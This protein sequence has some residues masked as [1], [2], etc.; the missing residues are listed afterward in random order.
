MA[1]GA[2]TWCSWHN[3]P[4]DDSVL[5]A[6]QDAGSAAGGVFLYACPPCRRKYGLVPLA[7]RPRAQAR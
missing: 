4:T 7:D 5:I 6:A 2:S 1:D 3:G